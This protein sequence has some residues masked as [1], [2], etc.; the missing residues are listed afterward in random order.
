MPIH[1]NM[2]TVARPLLLIAFALGLLGAFIPAADASTASPDTQPISQGL[3]STTDGLSD[4]T[5]AD[6]FDPDSPL[7]GS[8]ES[9]AVGDSVTITG[10]GY[11]H[12][13]GLSQWGAYGQAQA[14]RTHESILDFYYGG[15]SQDATLESY[16]TKVPGHDNLMVNLEYDRTDLLLRILNTGSTNPTGGHTPATVSVV[17]NS[18]DLTN[19]QTVRIVWLNENHCSFSFR[20]STNLAEIPF[21]EWL[22][23]SCDADITWDGEADSP[24]TLVQIEGCT[25]K[26]WDAGVYRPCQYGRGA[27][28]KTLD[29][30]SPQRTSAGID[31]SY[32]GFDLILEIDADDYTLGISEVSYSWPGAALRSQAIAARSY[33]AAATERYDSLSRKCGCDVYDTSRSQRYVGWGHTGGP[34]GYQQNWIDACEAT[35]NQV[36]THPSAPDNGVISAVYSAASGGASENNED[37]W[38]GSALPYLRSV[39]DSYDLIKNTAWS[40]SVPVDYFASRVG[41]DIVTSAAIAAT[42]VSGSPSDIAITGFKDGVETTKHYS[43]TQFMALFSGTSYWL[44]APRILSVVVPNSTVPP[45]TP[46]AVE[47]LWGEDRYAT[48]AAVSQDSYPQ[49]TDKVFVATGENFP[50]ALAVAPLAHALGGPILLTRRGSLPAATA[51]EIAR[52]GVS[53]VYILGGTAAVS[54]SVEAALAA[55]GSTTRIWGKDRY[56]TAA[57]ISKFAFPGGAQVAYVAVGTGFPDA[58]SGAP[59]AAHADGPLLLTTSSS[60]N[61]YTRQEL[62]RLSP[63]TIVVVGGGTSVSQSVV[64]QLGA[65]APNVVSIAAADRYATSVVVAQH[66]YPG[67]SDTV[68]VARGTAYPDALAGG[69]AAA[70]NAAPGPILLVPETYL[71]SSVAAELERLRPNRVVILGGTDAIS[72]GVQDAIDA[73]FD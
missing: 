37:I 40:R 1:I 31:A 39:P 61:G 2:T 29:N 27:S 70:D 23:V 20:N 24:S 51:A 5:G 52:L 32:N 12:G 33:A 36:L 3:P 49:G 41:L 35:D 64:N 42:Y 63:A 43:A 68:Y 66:G 17:G 9:Q 57:E 8:F 73:L 44:Q 67:G 28:I 46:V 53:N 60:L 25:L 54:S 55:Y 59:I 18:I 15:A 34:S 10:A 4:E 58:L 72:A 47:R 16:D 13:V 65:L 45:G 11:G 19:G 21:A 71:P 26:D 69:P 56:V 48:A 38:S 62:Q 14:G 22:D 30:E 6:L 7:G 50:D